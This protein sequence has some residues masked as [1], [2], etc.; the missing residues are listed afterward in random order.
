[1]CV[2]EQDAW[3]RECRHEEGEVRGEGRPVQSRESKGEIPGT[4]APRVC[5]RLLGNGECPHYLRD[6]SNVSRVRMA[7][8]IWWML[9]FG[10]RF[11]LMAAKNSRSCSSMPFMDT[12]TLDTSIFWSLPSTRSS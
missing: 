8:R 5:P 3:H 9:P 12:S 4:T 10:S 2:P 11:S 6:F 1:M 7:G